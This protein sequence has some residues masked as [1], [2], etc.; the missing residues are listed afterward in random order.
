MIIFSFVR[1]SVKTCNFL[2]YSF[3]APTDLDSGAEDEDVLMNVDSQSDVEV[4]GEPLME[5]D[6]VTLNWPVPNAGAAAGPGPGQVLIDLPPNIAFPL[7][8]SLKINCAF[9]FTLA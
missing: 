8:F 5:D 4:E 7:S 1:L 2:L 6:W 9:P 3:P